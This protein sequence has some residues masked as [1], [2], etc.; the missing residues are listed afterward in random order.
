V[1]YFS[2][3]SNLV[4]LAA[5]RHFGLQTG[6]EKK[7]PGANV[8][9]FLDYIHTY[10]QIHIDR[11]IYLIFMFVGLGYSLVMFYFLLCF[12]VISEIVN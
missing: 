9:I 11:P 10:D 4:T 7:L 6:K 8:M 12:I 3:S 5:K 2:D 1:D